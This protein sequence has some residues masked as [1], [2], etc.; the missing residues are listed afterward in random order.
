VCERDCHKETV[1]M[2]KQNQNCQA[3][4]ELAPPDQRLETIIISSSQL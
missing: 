2:P 3:T 4:E 1:L